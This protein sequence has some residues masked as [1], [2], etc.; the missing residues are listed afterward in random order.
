MWSARHLH[1]N[2]AEGMFSILLAGAESTLHDGA[3]AKEES[4]VGMTEEQLPEDSHSRRYHTD[5][6]EQ[7]T[8]VGV[9][10][11]SATHIFPTPTG[12]HSLY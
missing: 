2:D 5:R 12:T 4:Q 3:G 7:P 1:P 10:F 6:I 8:A 9:P 11:K